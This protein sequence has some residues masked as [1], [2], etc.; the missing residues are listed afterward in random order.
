M[1]LFS[2]VH[3][4]FS[5]VILHDVAH[6]KY[7]VKILKFSTINSVYGQ[8]FWLVVGFSFDVIFI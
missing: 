6:R 2:Y 7:K 3:V 1:L 8:F 5:F 4:Q